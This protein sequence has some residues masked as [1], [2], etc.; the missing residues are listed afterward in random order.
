MIK[1]T[2]SL[3][4]LILLQIDDFFFFGRK[5]RKNSIQNKKNR[6]NLD[7]YKV[8]NTTKKHMHA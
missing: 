7:A 6:S 2:N 1:A 3:F 4:S 5:H 8:T